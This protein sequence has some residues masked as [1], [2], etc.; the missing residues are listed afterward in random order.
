ME[1]SLIT[2]VRLRYDFWRGTR[3]VLNSCPYPTHPFHVRTGPPRVAKFKDLKSFV[4][5]GTAP[6]VYKL[7]QYLFTS[8]ACHAVVLTE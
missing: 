3:H 1:V 5:N 4:Q 6:F 8:T 7:T 2:L